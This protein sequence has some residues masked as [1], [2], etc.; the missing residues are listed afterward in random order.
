MVVLLLLLFLEH[1][2]VDIRDEIESNECRLYLGV[3][4]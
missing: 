4:K 3:E 2:V 1:N